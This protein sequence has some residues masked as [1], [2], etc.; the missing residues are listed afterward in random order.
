MT[1]RQGGGV[2]QGGIE[3]P[4]LCHP[5]FCRVSG[6]DPFLEPG[7]LADAR[8]RKPSDQENDVKDDC[9]LARMAG[10]RRR[11]GG[12]PFIEIVNFY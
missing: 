1:E 11:A 10:Q 3:A 12:A 7:T 8:E 5:L 4:P 6:E 9:T 2:A